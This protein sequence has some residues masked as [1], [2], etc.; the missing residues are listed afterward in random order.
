MDV[1]KFNTLIH[2]LDADGNGTVEKEEFTSAYGKLMGITDAD[3]LEK[4]WSGIDA[5]GDGSLTT[6][7]LARFYGFDMDGEGGA[8]EMSDE[9]IL[10]ALALQ[11]QLEQDNQAAAEKL[12]AE[13]AAAAQQET[14]LERNTLAKIN[15]ESCDK[16][17][18]STEA[19][20]Y[21]FL[22]CLTLGDLKH[23]AE[24]PKKGEPSAEKHLEEKL[25]IRVEDEKGETPLHKLARLRTSSM[26][27]EE[28]K[29][30]KDIFLKITNLM[31][32]QGKEGKGKSKLGRD[33]NHQCKEGKTPLYLAVEHSN[34][35]LIDLLFDLGTS[36]GPDPLLVNR[37]GWTI[38][39]AC[40][41]TDNLEILKHLVGRFTPARLK[42]LLN[43]GDKTGRE[44]VHIASYKCSEEMVKYLITLGATNLKKDASGNVPSVLAEKS[45]RKKSKEI[46]LAS[47]PTPPP[48]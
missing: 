44:P 9:K 35:L 28:K 11:T 31:R 14:M 24:G 43:A 21:Q 8:T 33:V 25:H 3:K 34:K 17:G 40:V 4:I 29:L 15:L 10:E 20:Q 36:E 47:M 2:L 42:Y 30:F 12:A 23:H 26:S 5:D 38:M 48:A 27:S 7:E 41:Q 1:D 32:E 22:S 45:G 46:L 6:E 18:S 13:K 19:R 37:V 16:M 39:H